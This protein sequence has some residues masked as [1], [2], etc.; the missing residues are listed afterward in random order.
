V[1]QVFAADFRDGL[2]APASSTDCTTIELRH[3][4]REMRMYLYRLE[5]HKGERVEEDCLGYLPVIEPAHLMVVFHH[6]FL[7]QWA[8]EIR[9]GK[10]WDNIERSLR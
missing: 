6:D 7:K 5:W 4:K 1:V 2:P 8:A 9:S 10:I 3:N